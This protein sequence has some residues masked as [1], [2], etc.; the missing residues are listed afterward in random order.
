MELQEVR[1]PYTYPA[2]RIDQRAMFQPTRNINKI[3]KN[4][5][6]KSYGPSKRHREVHRKSAPGGQLAEKRQTKLFPG[7]GV[8][9]LQGC[10][11]LMSVNA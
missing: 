10:M 5:Q 7:V 6:A 1:P 8:V 3:F 4:R 2:I 11:K 9:Y